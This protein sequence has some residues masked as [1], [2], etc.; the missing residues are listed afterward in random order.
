MAFSLR[1]SPSTQSSQSQYSRRRSLRR[2]A[3]IL[4]ILSLFG[5]TV[6]VPTAL[7]TYFALRSIQAEELA[8]DADLT[9]QARS[10]AEQVHLALKQDFERFE[11]NTLRRLDNR[12]SPLQNL[13]ELSPSLRT[14]FRFDASG[15]LAAPFV[16]PQN[17]HVVAPPPLYESTMRQAQEHE[18]KGR[19]M[20]ALPLYQSAAEIT[21]DPSL[22]GDALFASGRALLAAGKTEEALAI[23]QQVQDD[24]ANIRTS[25]GFRLG[26]LTRLRIAE[27]QLEDEPALAHAELKQLLES[28]LATRWVIAQAGE[29]TVARKALSYLQAHADSDW[30]AAVRS[31]LKIRTEQLYWASRLVDELELFTDHPVPTQSGEFSYYAR[32][33]AGSLWA[34]VW[35]GEDLYAFWF[36]YEQI[37]YELQAV[38]QRSELPDDDIHTQILNAATTTPY[39]PLTRQP[40]S[41]WLPSLSVVVNLENPEKISA[42]KTKK[43]KA[44]ATIIALALGVILLGLV[45]SARLV[46]Q[47]LEAARAKTDFA[48]N[49]SHELRSPITQIRL[50]AEALQL[51]LVPSQAEKERLYATIVREADRLSRL[52]DN[53]LDFSAIERG[54]KKYILRAEDMTEVVR[55]AVEPL[56]DTLSQRNID[57]EVNI[58]EDLPVVWVDREAIA[59]V[60]TNLL[61]NAF[62][63]GAEGGW[64]G[65]A[66]EET[67]D[68]LICTVSDRGIGIPSED[69]AHI[70]D[71]FY[72]SSDPEVRKMRGTGIGLSIVR[73]IIEAHA[74]R[75]TVNSTEGIGTTFSF[76]LPLRSTES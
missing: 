43:R 61:S 36:D 50:K 10:V 28:L 63:Y 49:V 41:P 53:V 34:T 1:F 4:R 24:F 69:Q 7:L 44:R 52:V 14:A 18:S 55:L 42:T 21:R 17:T 2:F 62:K 73:Y 5:A 37:F 76:S 23:F 66:I 75:V 3:E 20:L 65:V 60:L 19:P 31:R 13:S 16:L 25:L 33:E 15:T 6:L 64:I 22:H 72:R 51:D 32:P 26:D 54:S 68:A 8:L 38:K 58:P 30:L 67:D 39:M 74:G 45:L 48:A 9:R 12:E 70:F 47:E 71:D 46:G 57:I 59:Q 27:M 56:R 40:L 11:Y 35:W 29:A